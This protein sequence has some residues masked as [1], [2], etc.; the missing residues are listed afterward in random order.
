MAKADPFYSAK[1]M[2]VYHDSS[3]CTEGNNIERESKRSGTAGLPH[4]KTC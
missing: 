2:D 4:C 3:T 1:K